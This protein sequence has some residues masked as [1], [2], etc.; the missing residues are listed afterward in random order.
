MDI[1]INHPGKYRFQWRSLAS[2]DM[3]QPTV[4][5][6][7]DSWLRFVDADEFYG[8]LNGQVLC[9]QGGQS[10][11]CANGYVH[12]AS[13][14]GWLKVFKNNPGWTWQTR[15]SDF[16]DFNVIVEFNEAK[17]YTL[18]V[19][20]RSDHHLIDKMVLWRTSG[21]EPYESEMDAFAETSCSAS[22][23]TPEPTPEPTPNP[24]PEPTVAVGGGGSGPSCDFQ[25]ELITVGASSIPV[26]SIEAEEFVLTDD[27]HT[28]TLIS[29][30]L[31]SSYIVWEG[32]TYYNDPGFA[33]LSMDIM[34]NHP[35][36]YRFQW[37]SLASDDMS[38]PTVTDNNDSWLRFVDADE[39]YGE[40]NGQVLCPQGGQSVPCANGYVHGA[41]S[42]GWLK[43]FKNNPGWTWQ[44]RTSDF[45]DFNVFVEFNE[46]KVYTLEISAR[47]DE[48]LIDKMVLWRTDGDTPSESDMNAFAETSC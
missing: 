36:K 35:G 31:G 46:A 42:D 39:F 18:E 28:K 10:V 37:R 40:L 9:P 25:T 32:A 27:W 19:S 13:S 47:S 1:M 33:T 5:D 41:S 11:P 6:N 16:E 44:T 38:Q 24:T 26:L 12:G 3:S 30:Y 14:D 20:A 23:P 2:D 48:H 34:I 7:N 22:G 45:E 29:G 17:V 4:T 43:V 21:N 15:T 8:E